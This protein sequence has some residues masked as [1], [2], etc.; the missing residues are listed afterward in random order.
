VRGGK[1]KKQTAFI[2]SVTRGFS[3]IL[4]LKAVVVNEKKFEHHLIQP[5]ILR[6][7]IKQEWAKFCNLHI[8]M[9]MSCDDIKDLNR[10]N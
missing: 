8:I 5:Q 4:F 1:A 7:F 9:I 6:Q 2:E 10:A 3:D